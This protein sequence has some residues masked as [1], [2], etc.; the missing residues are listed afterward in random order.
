M[1]CNK[2]GG[3]KFTINGNPYF[4]LILIFNVGGAGDVQRLL[5]KGPRTNWM[6]MK[7][8][9]GQVWTYSGGPK[10]MVGQALSFQ[11]ITSDGQRVV[12]PNAAPSN[13]KF[14]Q[15]FEGRN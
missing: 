12:S 11:A 1:A 10:G 9:W 2:K 6:E 13:W 4:F 14:G 15:T 7:Q 8:N 5:I 3:M